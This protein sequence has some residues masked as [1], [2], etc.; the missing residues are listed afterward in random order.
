[1][2]FYVKFIRLV[3]NLD[4]VEYG[5]IGIRGDFFPFL[6]PMQAEPEKPKLLRMAIINL[7]IH[8]IRLEQGVDFYKDFY[9]E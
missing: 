2:Y 5:H 7:V 9:K 4:P 3:P 1:V 6:L 8:A